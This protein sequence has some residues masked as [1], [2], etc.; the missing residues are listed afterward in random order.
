MKCNLSSNSDFFY[1]IQTNEKE[2]IKKESLGI[3][4]IYAKLNDKHYKGVYTSI[5]LGPDLD[6]DFEN[7]DPNE[8]RS[9]K[10]KNIKL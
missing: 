7:D 2:F 5:N 9:F 8:K 6:F 1:G 3:V 10:T 4:S